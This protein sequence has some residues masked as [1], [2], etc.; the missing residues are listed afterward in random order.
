MRAPDL[1]LQVPEVYGFLFSPSRYKVAWGGRGSAKSWSFARALIG[2]AYTKKCRIL[3]VREYQSSISDSVHKLL[4]DQIATLGLSAYFDVQ[5]K[6]IICTLT[7]AEFLFKGLRRNV[8]EIKSTEGVDYVWVEESQSVSAESWQVLIPTIRRP[9]SEIW[10]S[11]N[12]FEVTDPTYQRFV[13]NADPEFA[14]SI[15]KTGWQD[16]PGFPEELNKERLYLLQS[17]PDAYSW[18]WDGLCR[19]VSDAVVFKGKYSI[20]AFDTPETARFYHGVDWGFASDP[21]V[22]V[23]SFIDKETLFIDAEAYG[24]GV[25]IDKLPELFDTIET[26]RDWPVFADNA[27]P[28]TISYMRRVGGINI[29]PADK[30]KGSVE[31]GIA[32]MKGF[33]S[34]VVHERCKQTAQ[35]FRLYSYKRDARTDEILPIIADKNGHC[36][37]A[38]RY[39]LNGFIQAR[40]QGGIWARL[41][42]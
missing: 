26:S 38:I 25:E 9:A 19:T 5:Q 21:T 36:L 12:P 34:I 1:K 13:V 28:E 16:N 6:A 7:G 15:V 8:Q 39:S 30:W 33:R 2:L 18:V 4:A 42:G 3:C 31:D 10:V 20:E 41:A 27:R 23:R 17:D 32:H 37:D 11:F 29:S 14:R 40:G 22:M 24:H 35:E